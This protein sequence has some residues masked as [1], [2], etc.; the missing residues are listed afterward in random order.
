MIY[1]VYLLILL[2]LISIE[3]NQKGKSKYITRAVISFLYVL[4]LGLR[5][6]NVGVDTPNYVESYFRFGEEGCPWMEPG[7]DFINR[8]CYK[9]H[10]GV[11]W[12]ILTVSFISSLFLYFT[13]LPLKGEKYSIAALCLNLFTFFSFVNIVRQMVA[14]SIFL[15]S[16]RF[17]RDRKL[18]LYILCIGLATTFHVTAI[19][20]LPLYLIK[21]RHLPNVLI[22]AIYLFSFIFLVVDS[23]QLLPS[24][25]LIGRSFESYLEKA[26]MR[27]FGIL[28]YLSQTVLYVV[29]LITMLKN[30]IFKKYPVL[31]NLV[32]AAMVLNN[33][34]I[35][36]P[37]ILRIGTYF[38]YFIFLMYP[39]IFY[40]C[41]RHIASRQLTIAII[42]FVEFAIWINGTF[43]SSSTVLPYYFYWE[44]VH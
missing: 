12:V 10:L 14:V 27:D 3:A 38:K 40:E 33:V 4:L 1:L 31:S 43:S 11:H 18:L 34:G 7:F 28:G 9:A 30:G 16:Y 24:L 21:N 23:S 29:V 6:E 19:L 42:M 22:V 15:F 20:L 41:K 2:L 37:I 5:G 32:F 8:T 26:E 25:N 39:I 36:I 13:L 17:I 44:N 35:H